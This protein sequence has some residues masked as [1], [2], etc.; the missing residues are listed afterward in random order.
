[1]LH[2]SIYRVQMILQNPIL[3]LSCLK[4]M[5]LTKGTKKAETVTGEHASKLHHS[6]RSLCS[7]QGMHSLPQFEYESEQLPI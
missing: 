6:G 4:A 5:L 2:N 7:S 1:M 3:I